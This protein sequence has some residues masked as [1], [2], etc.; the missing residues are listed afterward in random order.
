MEDRYFWVVMFP[1]FIISVGCIVLYPPDISLETITS[2]AI[3]I[4]GAMAVLGAGLQVWALLQNTMVK[5]F[6]AKK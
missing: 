2:V 5:T 6:L 1:L 4:M 3:A